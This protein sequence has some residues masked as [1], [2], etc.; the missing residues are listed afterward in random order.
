MIGE[1]ACAYDAGDKQDNAYTFSLG[2]QQVFLG[3][4]MAFADQKS[5]LAI[6]VCKSLLVGAEV[7]LCF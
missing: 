3:D 6:S 1:D 2:L 4:M 5:C 7:A